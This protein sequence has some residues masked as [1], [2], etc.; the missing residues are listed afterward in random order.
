MT[1]VKS[2]IKN[3]YQADNNLKTVFLLGHVPVPYAGNIAPDGHV[4]DHMGAWPADVFYADMDGNWTDASVNVTTTSSNRNYN[5]PEDGKYDQSVIPGKVEL[6]IGRVDFY[7]LP[8]FGV[9]E[10]TLTKRYLDKNM[11]SD[12]EKLPIQN[13]A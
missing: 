13:V 4:P 1:Q 3:K 8:V 10:L 9:D 6:E 12:Q 5:V 11:L 7:D 2:K